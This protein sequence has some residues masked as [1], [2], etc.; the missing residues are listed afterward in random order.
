MKSQ[1]T[2]KFQIFSSI[3]FVRNADSQPVDSKRNVQPLQKA[4]IKPTTPKKNRTLINHR[5]NDMC[6]PQDD[7]TAFHRLFEKN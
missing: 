4:N 6:A 7:N 3:L 2:V 1:L 5:Q